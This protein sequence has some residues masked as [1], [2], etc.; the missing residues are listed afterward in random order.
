M[1]YDYNKPVIISNLPGLTEFV[2]PNKTGYI[3]ESGNVSELSKI[4]EQT[5]QYNDNSNMSLHISNTKNKYS[6]KEYSK[7]LIN[8]VR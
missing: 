8:F 7:R 1:A 3:F 2:I 5:I 6:I 4:I